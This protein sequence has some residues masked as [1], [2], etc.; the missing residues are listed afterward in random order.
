MSITNSQNSKVVV[1]G[2]FASDVGATAGGAVNFGLDRSLRRSFEHFAVFGELLDAIKAR[3]IANSWRGGHTDGAFWR[4]LDF[5][6]DD[7]FGPIA[8]ARGDVSGQREIRQRGHGDVVRAADAGFEHAT[9]PDRGGFRLAEMVDAARGGGAADAC[10][11]A[12][13][14]FS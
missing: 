11:C 12:I 4:D 3:G 2:R 6:L 1:L 13:D 5:R 14:D 8:A 9:A 10:D 7:V